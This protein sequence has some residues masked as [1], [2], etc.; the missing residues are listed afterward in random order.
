[1]GRK[2]NLKVEPG[3]IRLASISL[4][5]YNKDIISLDIDCNSKYPE[6]WI[7]S[8]ED[9]IEIA[10]SKNKETL[11]CS[12]LKNSTRITLPKPSGDWSSFL[13]IGKYLIS[14]RLLRCKKTQSRIG[15]DDQNKKTLPT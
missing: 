14:F 1:M 3:I 2:L 7:I 13:N 15:F 9:D 12:E 8:G 10:L 11:R 5:A 6:A 4:L